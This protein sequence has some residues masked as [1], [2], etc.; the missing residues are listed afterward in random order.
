[1]GLCHVNPNLLVFGVGETRVDLDD[2]T[3]FHWYAMDRRL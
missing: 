1:M 2:T 3:L